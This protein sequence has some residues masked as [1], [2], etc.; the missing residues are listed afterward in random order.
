M[1]GGVYYRLVSWRVH[2]RRHRAL[3]VNKNRRPTDV[4]V[5]VWVEAD[6]SCFHL[7]TRTHA[8]AHGRR[9]YGDT[10]EG[11]RGQE[12]QRRLWPRV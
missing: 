1:C 7:F 2:S 8:C 12:V 10:K 6:E 9:G 5:S 11:G 4:R 3:V